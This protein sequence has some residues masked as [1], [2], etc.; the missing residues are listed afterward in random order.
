MSTTYNNGAGVSNIAAGRKVSEKAPAHL[1]GLPGGKSTVLAFPRSSR[2]TETEIRNNIYGF[3]LDQHVTVTL[4]KKSH[5]LR[6]DLGLVEPPARRWPTL[7]R[8][9]YGLTQVYHEV[10]NEF[11]PLFRRNTTVRLQWE[12]LLQYSSTVFHD[13]AA[14]KG[15]LLI[16]VPGEYNDKDCL[17]H[18]AILLWLKQKAPNLLIR[19]ENPSYSPRPYSFLGTWGPIQPYS[20]RNRKMF[21]EFYR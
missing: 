19:I 1:L 5:T 3:V 6:Y 20:V 16:E 12:T 15:R 8:T 18:V 14:G 10:R 21:A 9:S 17:D 11:L 7:E 13:P 2:L 4:S